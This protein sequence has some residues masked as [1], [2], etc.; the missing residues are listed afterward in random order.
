MD[1]EEQEKKGMGWVKL[2]FKKEKAETNYVKRNMEANKTFSKEH[3]LGQYV[4]VTVFEKTHTIT[5]E[6]I[7]L[8]I[9]F[10]HY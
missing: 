9:E 5:L 2:E 3:G 10:V 1:K 8:W 6:C 4:Y 7:W